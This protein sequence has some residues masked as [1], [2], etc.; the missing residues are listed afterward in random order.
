MTDRVWVEG[1]IVCIGCTLS[2]EYGVDA[3]CTLHAWHAQGFLDRDGR[4]WTFV[5]NNR[6]HRVISNAKLRGKNVKV[7]GWPLKKHR[8]LEL[9]KY[10]LK[11]GDQWVGYDFC[12]T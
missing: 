4:L 7:Y 10:S 2:G 5:D 3:Q 12:K 1:K 8:Y 9:W 6:G 11:T